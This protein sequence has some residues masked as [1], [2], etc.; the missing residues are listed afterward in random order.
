MHHKQRPKCLELNILI[1]PVAVVSGKI[2]FVIE[3]KKMKRQKDCVESN[4]AESHIKESIE[5]EGLVIR[6]IITTSGGL[7]RRKR[8]HFL[9]KD[10]NTEIIL[11]SRSDVV[12][13]L[14]TRKDTKLVVENFCF[15]LKNTGLEFCDREP[16]SHV[17]EVNIN[18]LSIC[19]QA[20]N[21]I[22]GG[23]K[24]IEDSVLEHETWAFS[25]DELKEANQ[26]EFKLER[27][28]GTSG[29]DHV[30]RFAKVLD[31][32]HMIRMKNTV[33][34]N[35]LSADAV[36]QLKAMITDIDI[37]AD[38]VS[39]AKSLL[40]HEEL[41]FSIKHCL[42]AQVET[43]I[44]LLSLKDLNGSSMVFPPDVGSNIYCD[45]IE[46]AFSRMPNL[47]EFLVNIVDTNQEK[48]TPNYAIRCA[49]LLID[50]MRC[51]DRRHSSLQ[52]INTLHLLY[53]KSFVANL[54]TFGQKGL[55]TGYTEATRLI[56]EMS[57]LSEFFKS[58]HY[59]INLGMQITADNVDCIM[60]GNLEHWI[61]AFSRMDPINT[62]MLSNEVPS[63]DAQEVT[64]DIVYLD[65]EE[66]N[67]LKQCCRIVLSKKLSDL[68]IGMTSILKHV[69]YEPIHDF[70][71][72][73][74]KQELFFE[75]LE[76]LFE[77]EHQGNFT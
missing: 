51:K 44:E 56:D 21:S 35:S 70:P 31:L 53:Q 20:D 10:E 69:P 29:D 13:F 64:A 54:K 43:E 28:K 6:R 71:E 18:D 72:M 36:L 17:P 59:S 48:L 40:K 12:R 1:H 27:L 11:R 24:P 32:L 49:N 57:E 77:M 55:C 23:V 76:P 19:M 37:G 67:H 38:P 16:F 14:D 45:V 5:S 60:K 26:F 52:K 30:D 74:D 39:L 47:L 34:S 68:K 22:A 63:F 33:N 50:I 75:S 25:G 42:Q 8:V 9:V 15:K 2:L 41:A 3:K 66:L 73:L 4:F 65:E 61:L 46:E 62:H 58:S 7:D